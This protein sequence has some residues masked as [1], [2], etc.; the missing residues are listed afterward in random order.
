MNS[1]VS[2][3]TIIT[4]TLNAA[5]DVT[6]VV[7]HFIEEN[8]N[9]VQVVHSQ[10]GGKGNNVARTVHRLGCKT[11]ACGWIGGDTGQR[12]RNDIDHE[13]IPQSFCEISQGESRTCL[14]ILEKMTGKITELLEPGLSVTQTDIIHFANHLTELIKSSDYVLFLGSLPLGCDITDFRE[15]VAAASRV[16]ARIVLDTSGPALSAGALWK[17]YILKSNEYETEELIALLNLQL[18]FAATADQSDRR[19]DVLKQHLNT[20]LEW[21]V[22]LPIIT[23]GSKGAIAL[24]NGSVYYAKSSPIH[25][26]NAV[27]SGDAFLGGLLWGLVHGVNFEWALSVAIAAGAQNATNLTAGQIDFSSV[28]N[29]AQDVMISRL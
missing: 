4:V 7:D 9:R 22:A 23:L 28:M 17:P 12:I 20:L 14:T 11:V 1:S 15:I 21:G 3:P 6:Y 19:L 18:N 25:S 10:G 8:T 16:G 5:M 13:G 26:I 29:L 2:V 27:G 24:H